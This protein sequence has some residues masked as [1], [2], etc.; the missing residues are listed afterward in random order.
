MWLNDSC[1]AALRAC[2]T[3]KDRSVNLASI[4]SINCDGLK[5]SHLALI[6]RQGC[7]RYSD[8]CCAFHALT[9]RVK[10]F[11]LRG[12]MHIFDHSLFLSACRMPRSSMISS[13]PPGI[14]YERTSRYRR[15]TFSPWPPLV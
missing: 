10:Q 1:D 14:A 8:V 11:F 9:L 3:S 13:E 2:T 5:G 15:S 12:G 7:C 4:S 6:G